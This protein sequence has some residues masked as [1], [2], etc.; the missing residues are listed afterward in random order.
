MKKRLTEEQIIRC[1]REQESGVKVDDICRKHGIGT[2]TFYT[3]KSKF[4]GMEVSE[5]KRLRA[6]EDENRRL[7]QLVAE[8]TLDIQAL[9]LL[10]E[11][12]W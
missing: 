6:I 1:L 9:K 2:S 10:N 5:V 3:W 12:K 11:K 4:G 7:K 8:L